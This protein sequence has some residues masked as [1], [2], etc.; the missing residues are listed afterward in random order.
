MDLPLPLPIY[1]APPPLTVLS[2][3]NLCMSLLVSLSSSASACSW[4]AIASCFS[5]FSSSCNDAQRRRS[6]ASCTAGWDDKVSRGVARA[7][8]FRLGDASMNQLSRPNCTSSSS[9]FLSSAQEDGSVLPDMVARGA[10]VVISGDGAFFPGETP[11][12]LMILS[13]STW[14]SMHGRGRKTAWLGV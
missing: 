6:A 13:L 5:F 14:C 4:R 2:S 3:S 11:G 12:P 9:A 10:R 8:R 1:S 7:T